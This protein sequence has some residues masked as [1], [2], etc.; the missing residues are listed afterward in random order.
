MIKNS[1]IKYPPFFRVSGDNY[2]IGYKIG[3]TFKDRIKETLD[4]F[5]LF[6]KNKEY[7]KQN[8]LILEEVKE[9]SEKKFPQYMD[10]LRGYADGS[11]I[12]FQDIF[13]HNCMHVHGFSNCS[14]G[15]FTYKDHT[16]IVQNEDW[17]SI[18]GDNAYFLFQ[19]LENGISFFAYT[20]PGILPGMSFG[21]N[22]EGMFFCCNGLNDP[23]RSI[24]PSRIMFGRSM[25]EQKTM[26]DTLAAAQRYSPR[27]GSANYNIVSKNTNEVVNLETTGNDAF[28]TTITDR[29][30]H[31]NHF[32]SKGFAAKYPTAD[33]GPILTLSRYKGAMRILHTVDK[34][35]EGLQSILW[36]DSVFLTKE[37]TKSDNYTMCTAVVEITRDADIVLKFFPGVRDHE[38]YK[39]FS[40]HRLLAG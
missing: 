15:I 9:V 36:D 19:E 35:K 16:T 22:S 7:S 4:N 21:F 40:L 37:R 12:D 20:Y 11:G 17:W 6:K 8:P 2:N 29:F 10:E 18:L 33:E 30:F 1:K 23:S 5:Q 34:T 24:G 14:T 38:E 31:S 27:S 3:Q 26:K 28:E 13:I 25:F 39:T 32:V